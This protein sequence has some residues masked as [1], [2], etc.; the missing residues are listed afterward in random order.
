MKTSIAPTSLRSYDAMNGSGFAALQALII[1][2][3]KPGRIY[4]RRQLAQITGL[5]TSCI[6]GRVHE[7][8]KIGS[9]E[10]V[11]TIKCPLSGRQVEA[12][13]KADEQLHLLVDA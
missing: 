7:L 5:E 4:S 11:G 3:M 6:A 13:K 12:V 2:K 1:N 9:L 10:V 8:I